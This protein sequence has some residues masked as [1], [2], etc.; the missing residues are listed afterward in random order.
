[1]SRETVFGA[2]DAGDLACENEIGAIGRQI[3]ALAFEQIRSR[4]AIRKDWHVVAL[5]DR[6]G[7]RRACIHDKDTP[8]EARQIKRRGE[9]RGPAADDEA[10]EHRA[11]GACH[12]RE[13]A[14]VA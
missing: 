12:D 5:G 7:T 6:G 10:V 9:A 4:N 8:F 11:A 1:M 13:S 3:L 2:L 14:D